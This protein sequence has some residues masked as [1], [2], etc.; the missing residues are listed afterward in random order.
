MIT[1]HVYI[2]IVFFESALMLYAVRRIF[3]PALLAT[4][5]LSAFLMLMFFAFWTNKNV[6]RKIASMC[7]MH[8][9]IP[10]VFTNVPLAGFT[11]KGNGRFAV[12]NSNHFAITLMKDIMCILETPWELS[13]AI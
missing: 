12:G 3:V 2:P 13:A 6:L 5:F 8:V 1:I 11:V 4:N 10:T 7:F 9:L